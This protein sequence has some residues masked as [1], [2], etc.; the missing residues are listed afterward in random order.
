MTITAPCSSVVKQHSDEA[1]ELYSWAAQVCLL[2]LLLL[3]VWLWARC[4]TSLYLGFLQF[5]VLKY[6]ISVCLF[7]KLGPYLH[8]LT[9]GKIFTTLKFMV[10]KKN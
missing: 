7:L 10:I 4:L 2:A 9:E 6:K 8:R 1:H 3:A 5:V